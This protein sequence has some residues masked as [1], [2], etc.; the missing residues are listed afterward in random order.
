MSTG[1]TESVALAMRAELVEHVNRTAPGRPFG[2]R[3]RFPLLAVGIAALIGGGVAAAAQLGVFLPGSTK[4]TALGGTVDVKAAGS[5]TIELGP[6]P[7][8]ANRVDY[9]FYC[10][11][12]GSFVFPDGAHETCTSGDNS[13]LA[14][15]LILA[16]NEHSI[17]VTASPAQARWRLIAGYVHST[18]TAWGINAKGQTYGV[19]NS[20][21]VPD[22]VAVIATNGR[23]GYAF[24]QQIVGPAPTSPAQAAHWH[25]VSRL[26]PVYQ[27]D[28][29][30]VIGQYRTG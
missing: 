10:L 19:Q 20:R 29:T 13:V 3:R 18:I 9:R 28:G 22:L 12:A 5:K 26:I 7:A 21:G 11:S 6:P 2:R 23:V 16:P 8:G 27:P 25:P 30:T 1:M 17:R 24:F 4:V 15:H 14:Y